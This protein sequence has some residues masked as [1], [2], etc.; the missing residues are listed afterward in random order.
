MNTIQGS[1]YEMRQK[2]I[3]ELSSIIKNGIQSKSYDDQINSV[4]MGQRMNATRLS[5]ITGISN[6]KIDRI[7]NGKF[8][9]SINDNILSLILDTL[10][11]S[12]AATNR[13]LELNKLLDAPEY[14]K[15]L[16]EKRNN[17]NAVDDESL[18]ELIRLLNASKPNITQQ[19]LKAYMNALDL[20]LIKK[21]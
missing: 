10:N 2:L 14:Q 15:P 7:V 9:R 4:P 13:A 18:K 17:T 6:D 20:K 8:N 1:K 12:S 11:M 21:R 19:K 5:K 3:D 16:Q